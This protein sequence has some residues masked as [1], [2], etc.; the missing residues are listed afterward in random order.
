[1]KPQDSFGHVSPTLEM[2]LVL[3]K[4]WGNVCVAVGGLRSSSLVLAVL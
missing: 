1:M 3:L 4:A 2:P